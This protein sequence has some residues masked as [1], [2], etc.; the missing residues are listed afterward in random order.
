M[1]TVLLDKL[2]EKKRLLLKDGFEIIGVFG[3]YARGDETKDSDIDLLYDIKPIFMQKY[4]GFQA[5]AKLNEIREEL[6]AFL[7][8]DID[9]ATIDNSSKTFKEYALKDIVYV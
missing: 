1:D 7:K 3:S 5:F 9:I 6:K 8:R 2:K 4:E